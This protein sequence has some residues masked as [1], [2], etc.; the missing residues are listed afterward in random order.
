M[1]KSWLEH[2]IQLL[3]QLSDN[4][5]AGIDVITSN[6]PTRLATLCQI[7]LNAPEVGE[8]QQVVYIS[9]LTQ[10]YEKLWNSLQVKAMISTLPIFRKEQRQKLHASLHFLTYVYHYAILLIE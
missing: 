2:D 3:T 7:N 6:L 1:L 4:D 5:K 8:T 10:L 9:K